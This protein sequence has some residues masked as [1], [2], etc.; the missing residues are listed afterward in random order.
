MMQNQAT[1]QNTISAKASISEEA[2]NQLFRDARRDPIR[3]TDTAG[4]SRL[5]QL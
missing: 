4:T 3:Q 2:L 1:K 5:A